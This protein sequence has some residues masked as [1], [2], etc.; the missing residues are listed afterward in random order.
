MHCS[1]F[2]QETISVTKMATLIFSSAMMR[3]KI[4]LSP[5]TSK[6]TCTNKTYPQCTFLISLW[7]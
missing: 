7:K 1:H 3:N 4:T 6:K 5:F 2:S